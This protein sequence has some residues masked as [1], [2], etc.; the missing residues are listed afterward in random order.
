MSTPPP[1]PWPSASTARR[2]VPR[3]VQLDPRRAPRR[4]RRVDVDAASPL[5][6]AAAVRAAASATSIRSGPLLST[7]LTAVSTGR[8]SRC[9]PLASSHGHEQIGR[10]VDG[11]DPASA[12]RTSAAARA[13]C[14]R[15]SPRAHP[16]RGLV[17]IVQVVSV[18][19]GGP[20]NSYSPAKASGCPSEGVMYIG[21][22]RPALDRP[23]TR[24][25]RRQGPDTDAWHRRVRNAGL[26]AMLSMRALNIRGPCCDPWPRTAPA[27]T[28]RPAAAASAS[29]RFAV[30][31]A[32]RTVDDDPRRLGGS[33]V[34]VGFEL[35]ARGRV[36]RVEFVEQV[37]VRAHRH[38]PAAHGSTVPTRPV[39]AR[40]GRLR[41]CN[42]GRRPRA[43]GPVGGTCR[44][45]RV[46]VD[47]EPRADAGRARRRPVA[48]QRAAVGP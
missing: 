14:G 8:S 23:A 4:R 38:V 10:V 46:E 5:R 22:L 30:G 40:Y 20:Q 17:M 6:T 3:P 24:T 29:G 42:L 45:A 34:V 43:R 16:R 32:Q 47:D 13:A 39:R 35:V 48:H 1:A 33:H 28:R 25:S 18:C 21:C 7:L 44:A 26:V 9:S 12:P 36:D 2:S 41:V 19:P 31:V 11:R 27:P 37:G 15:G